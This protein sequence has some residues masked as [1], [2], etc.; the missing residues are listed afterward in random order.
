MSHTTT[1]K[2]CGKT[3]GEHYALRCTSG[4]DE[5]IWEPAPSA[6]ETQKG[7]AS[8]PLPP[9]DPVDYVLW[10][11][12]DVQADYLKQRERQLTATLS[13]V[14]RLKEDYADLKS[15]A[16]ESSADY[17]RACL[18][19]VQLQ[20]KLAA[21]L[22]EVA[23]L[24]EEKALAAGILQRSASE[25]M[26]FLSCK[27]NLKKAQSKLRALQ[28]SHDRLIHALRRYYNPLSDDC[29]DHCTHNCRECEA[30]AA[31]AAAEELRG[32]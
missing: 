22:A 15:F 13:E 4:S 28:A 12:V 11:E 10:D 5:S 26:K 19:S 27:D 17:D 9:L 23:R 6:P 3:F 14:A 25:V 1:C 2:H 30:R 21:A 7:A 29:G 24:K 8:E 20:D 31:I 16:D 32:K 18:E